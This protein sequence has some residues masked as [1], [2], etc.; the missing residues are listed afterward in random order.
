MR[1]IGYIESEH[2]AKRFAEF[3]SAQGI[4]NQLE[5]E[6]GRGWAI[7]VH[8]EEQ[9]ERAK[10]LMDEFKSNPHDA[11]FAPHAR[12]AET[13]SPN[14]TST[15]AKGARKIFTRRELFGSI[16]GLG[17]GPLTLGLIIASVV[18]FV[19][20]D[21][22]R[23][24]VENTPSLFIT[25]VQRSGFD[26]LYRPGL[27]EVRHGQIWRLVTPIFIHL[28]FLH[29]FF[30]LFWLQDL[31]GMI[32]GRLGTLRLARLVFVIAALSN[33]AEFLW[34]GPYFG[35][36][37][38]VVYGLIGYIWMKGKFDPASGV[39]LH[40]WIVGMAGIW[41]LLCMAGVVHAAN[42][43]HTVGLVA[44]TIWGYISGKLHK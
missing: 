17:F 44:G 39:V 23:R 8:A 43:A 28:D 30:N 2:T 1:L 29:I 9:I 34:S 3:L 18:V 36:M 14:A 25:H 13:I 37:S 40:P 24:P 31:G 4:E 35:G 42:A 10:Q 38:G 15:R 27:V 19:I 16:F 11:R 5:H 20:S 32:E 21:F 12:V 7:W 41:F 26:I 6:K 22:G 33:V